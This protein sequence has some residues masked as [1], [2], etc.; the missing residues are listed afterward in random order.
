MYP[1][2]LGVTGHVFRTGEIMYAN[3]MKSL[4][5]YLPSVDNLSN[6]NDVKS[7]LIVPVY[8]H[9]EKAKDRKPVAIL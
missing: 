2:T 4:A 7:L 1:A 8:G 5:A 3:D 9:R 6:V